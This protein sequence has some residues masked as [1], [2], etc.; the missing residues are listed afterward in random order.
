MTADPKDLPDAYDLRQTAAD[1]IGGVGFEP[2]DLD[3]DR[4]LVGIG[5]G[6]DARWHQP[7]LGQEL[8]RARQHRGLSVGFETVSDGGRVALKREDGR[9]GTTPLQTDE[10]RRSGLQCKPGC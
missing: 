7:A 8:E 10:Q 6:E 4:Q 5:L 3:L 9:H 1:M 2:L